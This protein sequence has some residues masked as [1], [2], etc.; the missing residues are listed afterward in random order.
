MIFRSL[1]APLSIALTFLLTNIS[2]A[3]QSSANAL[4]DM[5]QYT[6]INTALEMAESGK[7]MITKRSC[8][9]FIE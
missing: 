7:T 6:R 3:Q 2:A 8:E 5:I 1:V 9:S 4:F